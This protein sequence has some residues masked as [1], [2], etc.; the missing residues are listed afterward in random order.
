MK[1]LFAH[2]HRFIPIDNN[3]YSE[4]Q[5]PASM[6]ERYLHAFDELMVVARRGDMPNG[7]D[8]GDLE[9]SSRTGVHFRFVPNL[10]NPKAQLTCR[11]KARDVV[12]E[13]L[14]DADAVI[15]RLPSEIGL[16]A[17]EV[18][19]RKGKT[20]AVEVAGCPWD[21]LLNYGSWNA[22]VYAPVMAWRMQQ[23]VS[24]APFTLYVT[25]RFLQGRYP[26]RAGE[27]VACSNV[28]IPTPFEVVLKQR[29]A[30]IEAGS[31]PLVFG[32]IGTL[33]TRF[34]G[35]QTVLAALK[36]IREYLPRVEFHVLGGGDSDP[37]QVEAARYGVTDITFFDGTLPAGDPVLK[38][39]DEVDIYLQPSFKEGLPRALIEAMSRGCPAIGST[40][41]GIPEILDTDCLIR[42]GNVDELAQQLLRAA[43][44]QQWRLQQAQ[45][46]W[47]VACNYSRDL[48][49]SRRQA[50]W[51]R[52][53]D[54]VNMKKVK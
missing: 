4:T 24:R 33:K 21:G 29:L 14:D 49:D 23:A 16:L 43:R 27:T 28:E 3:V 2:D 48:L 11:R 50:F 47:A 40:C 7:K 6:W 52:F 5:F 13:C 26:C 44:N 32:L 34:K 12:E 51:R 17:V 30:R 20:W 45:R 41:A 9:M 19:R 54:Y 1:C 10:S 8:V 42:P 22:K 38:W 53:A 31:E 36:K 39:L 46:N 37:W 35:I 25:E 15:A 18:A